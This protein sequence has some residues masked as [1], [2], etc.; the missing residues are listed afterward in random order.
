M[1]P[2][3]R[4]AGETGRRQR[5][6]GALS[7]LSVLPSGGVRA[8]ESAG[9]AGA[10]GIQRDDRR[11]RDARGKYGERL[12][13]HAARITY[14]G[15]PTALVEFAGLRFLTD[16]TFAPAGTAYSTARYTLRKRAGPAVPP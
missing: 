14:V 13:R 12:V 2:D 1:V 11:C 10:T 7:V 4:S 8:S 3:V 5:G 6:H 9:R 16:P 15:G